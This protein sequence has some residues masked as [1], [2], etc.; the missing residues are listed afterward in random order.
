MIF[1]LKALLAFFYSFALNSSEDRHSVWETTCS[2][3]NHFNHPSPEVST[4][5]NWFPAEHQSHPGLVSAL[6]CS[7]GLGEVRGLLMG[8]T[9]WHENHENISNRKHWDGQVPFWALIQ[10]GRNH[11]LP[12]DAKAPATRWSRFFCLLMQFAFVAHRKAWS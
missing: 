11:M 2:G 12:E 10:L 4:I 1:K 7:A 3:C 6:H 9:L 5:C 8:V